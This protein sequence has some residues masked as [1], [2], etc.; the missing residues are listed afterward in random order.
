[1]WMLS[2]CIHEKENKKLLV[3]NNGNCAKHK[4]ANKSTAITGVMNEKKGKQNKIKKN[5]SPML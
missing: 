3:I 1:M 4:K 2:A 5:E